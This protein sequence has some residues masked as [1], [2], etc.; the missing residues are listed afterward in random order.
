MDKNTV[1]YDQMI[2]LFSVQ[3]NAF[4]EIIHANTK[5][6]NAKTISELD[7]I[8][9][10]LDGVINRQDKV[11]GAVAENSK[12]TRT[13]NRINKN[14]KYYVIGLFGFTYFICWIYETFN[15]EDIVL[16]L[17]NKI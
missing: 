8:D 11:N 16:K 15:L 4:T 12:T 9:V 13:V 3:Q 5:A 10:K 14:L 6:I 7:R 1:S 2:N 17:I